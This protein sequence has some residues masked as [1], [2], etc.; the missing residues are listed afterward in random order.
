MIS[1]LVIAAKIGFIEIFNNKLRSFLSIFAISIG[2]FTFLFVFSVINYSQ[3]VIARAEK[4]AGANSFVFN[5]NRGWR[6]KLK[7]DMKSFD[8]IMQKF[9]EITVLS[10]KSSRVGVKSF[11]LDNVY[12]EATFLGITPNWH[13]HDWVYGKVK[14]RFINWDDV[15]QRRKVAVFVR[16]PRSN[17]DKINYDWESG[18]YGGRNNSDK[19]F[20][21]EAGNKSMLG[22]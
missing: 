6:N 4:L 13:K 22:R 14:G 7:L 10:P 8:E 16:D 21:W 5:V 1:R 18:G 19:K 15:T 17:E 2:V 11:R 3:E 9:P 20:K 12:Y